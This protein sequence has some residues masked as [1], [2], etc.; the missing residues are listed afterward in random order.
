[1]HGLIKFTA[2]F[3][4]DVNPSGIHCVQDTMNNGGNHRT[5]GYCSQRKHHPSRSS[6]IRVESRIQGGYP[7]LSPLLFAIPYGHFVV[8]ICEELIQGIQFIEL[9]CNS[10]SNSQIQKE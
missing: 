7:L 4:V 6:K 3:V 2:C 8:R 1:M 9:F 5:Y 10:H